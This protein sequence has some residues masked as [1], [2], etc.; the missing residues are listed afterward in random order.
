MTIREHLTTAGEVTGRNVVKLTCQLKTGTKARQLT[1]VKLTPRLK[2]SEELMLDILMSIEYHFDCDETSHACRHNLLVT[3]FHV[4]QL[5]CYCTC[6]R[7]KA[8][9]RSPE[10][11]G[12][13]SSNFIK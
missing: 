5:G 13:M 7:A 3:Y 6:A 2:H 4:S 11:L 9:P 1:S 12:R 8:V 10:R